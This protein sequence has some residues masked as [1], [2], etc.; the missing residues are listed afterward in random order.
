M[1]GNG[2]RFAPLNHIPLMD[3]QVEYPF[4]KWDAKFLSQRSRLCAAVMRKTDGKP[5]GPRIVPMSAV[6]QASGAGRSP[7]TP[8]TQEQS[9]AVVAVLAEL[10][11]DADPKQVVREIETRTGWQLNAGEVGALIAA[12]QERSE[13]PPPLDQPP[14]ENA[15]GRNGSS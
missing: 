5:P 10:G 13:T 3:R 8:T 7:A 4:V 12:L 11:A 15:R 1:N 9:Q 14:P 2:T 6:N